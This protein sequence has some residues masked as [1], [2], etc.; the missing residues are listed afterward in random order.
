[1]SKR[2]NKTIETEACVDDFLQQVKDKQKREESFKIKS[3]MEEA[4]GAPAKMW[5]G[6]IVGFITNTTVAERVTS[7]R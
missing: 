1:M 7:L 2:Q 3:M 4:T 5:G 6:S